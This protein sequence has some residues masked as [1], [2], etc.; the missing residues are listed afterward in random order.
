MKLIIFSRKSNIPLRSLIYN[1]EVL[2]LSMFTSGCFRLKI[3]IIR[4]C[5]F[6][7]ILTF[8]RTRTISIEQIV[9]VEWMH[10]SQDT[11]E[12][13]VWK[14]ICI[15]LISIVTIANLWLHA[16]KLILYW[17]IMYFPG[18]C[19]IHYR[20]VDVKIYTCAQWEIVLH[21]HDYL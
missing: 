21:I 11:E 16:C 2:K 12:K 7:S 9:P 13:I 20:L 4:H 14:I 18:Y 3:G 19:L 10:E 17:S 5:T 6:K 1:I 15:L 8:D